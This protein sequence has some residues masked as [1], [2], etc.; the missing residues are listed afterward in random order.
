MKIN[1]R[2]LAFDAMLAAMCAVLGYISLDMGNM[3]ITFESLPILLGALLFGP[4]DG[5]LI[6]L[7]GTG[8]YQILRYGV[9]ATTVLWML[10]YMVC[11]LLVGLYAKKRDFELT[12]IQV[13]LIVI[14]NELLITILNTGVMYIDSKIYG[15]YSFAYIFGS[16]IIR[17]VICVVKATAFALI[18]P[19]LV[20]A[21]RKALGEKT[22]R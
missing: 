22:A 12:G 5:F 11:G 13:M 7:V 6:G 9:T 10:P 14:A 19:V 1:T 20:K 21:V 16:T 4:V 8:I 3:K 15:Y 2:Q 18:L 17:L